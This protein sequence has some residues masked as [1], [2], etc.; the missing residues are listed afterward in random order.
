MT[1]ELTPAEYLALTSKPKKSKLRN[2]K[3]TVDGIT[4]DSK[5]EANR[6]SELKLLEQAGEITDLVLQ[7][8][9][10]LQEGFI[11]NEG[12]RRLPITYKADFQY[13][14]RQAGRVVIEDTK[15]FESKVFKL[16]AK[17]FRKK[18]PELKFVVG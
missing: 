11:D 17:M 9:F 7:P 16:K 12:K 13:F 4:F 1:E 14:D 15:G 8:V 3:T 10:V 2:I 18:Y 6:Y 5:K